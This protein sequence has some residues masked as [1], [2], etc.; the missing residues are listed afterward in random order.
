MHVK[1]GVRGNWKLQNLN[2]KSVTFVQHAHP[3]RESMFAVWGMIRELRPLA[4]TR[5][6]IWGH[7]GRAGGSC[8]ISGVISRYIRPYRPYIE[9]LWY[10]GQVSVQIACL[11]EG[12]LT[13]VYTELFSDLSQ[14][15]LLWCIPYRRTMAIRGPG[16][17]RLPPDDLE[18]IALKVPKS[19]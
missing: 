18:L 17:Q 8:P 15:S 9:K 3:V 1:R 19:R 10:L 5:Y 2:L 12:G 6:G 16:R 4:G 14:S 13:L 11:R 7:F